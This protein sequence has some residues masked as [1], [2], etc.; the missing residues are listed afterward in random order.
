MV[1]INF[2]ICAAIVL[3]AGTKLSK[4]GDA[5]SEKTHISGAWIGFL[6]LATITSMP[7]LVTGISSVAVV[8]VPDMAIGMV[9]GS[10][11]FNLAII[12]VLDIQSGR[13]SLI[14]AASSKHMLSGAFCILIISM[15]GIGILVST[16]IAEISVGDFDLFSFLLL[17]SYLIILR[18]IYNSD[19]KPGIEAGQ[20]ERES[21][22][23]NMSLR[24]TYISFVVATLAIIGSSIWLATIGDE[25]VEET[26]W[27]AGFVGN[28][29]LAVIS[30]LPELTVCM[31]AIKLGAVDMAIGDILGSNMFNT[32]IIIAACDIAYRSDSIFA[33][34]STSL[35]LPA[36]TAIAMTLV[37]MIGLRRRSRRKLFVVAGWEAPLLLGLWVAGSYLLFVF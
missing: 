25:I 5:I 13:T 24:R 31:A 12:A 6:L 2:I 32:G 27:E 18:V 8:E 4:Y 14:A 22:Y 16:E 10:N 28:L 37:V 35:A 11:L 20:P 26:G 15:A 30:S 23:G 1:W 17:A 33:S 9:L 29:F 7:E 34:T 36:L 3:I 21:I 19:R